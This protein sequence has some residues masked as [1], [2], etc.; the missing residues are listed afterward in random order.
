[1]GTVK[2]NRSEYPFIQVIIHHS[3]YLSISRSANRYLDYPL[4]M[5]AL[6]R[7]E[8][9]ASLCIFVVASR[10]NGGTTAITKYVPGNRIL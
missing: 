3:L 5:T 9:Q 4:P 7:A 6:V 8:A 2:M 10:C 1:M